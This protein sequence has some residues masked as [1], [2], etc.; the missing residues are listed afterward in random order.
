MDRAIRG[1]V[2]VEIQAAGT[3]GEVPQPCWKIEYSVSR[4][5]YFFGVKFEFVA[6]IWFD[7]IMRVKFGRSTQ[8]RKFRFCGHL[9]AFLIAQAARLETPLCSCEQLGTIATA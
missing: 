6:H 3:G 9:H 5:M 1:F 7:H 8:C 4:K 2:E